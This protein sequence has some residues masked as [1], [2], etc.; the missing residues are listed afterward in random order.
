MPPTPSPSAKAS[1]RGRRPA[2]DDTAIDTYEMS[3]LIARTTGLKPTV[4][5]SPRGRARHDA[6]VKVC[7]TPEKTDIDDVAVVGIRPR[8]RL[9]AGNLGTADLAAV[10]RWTT[11]NEPAL[12]EFWDERSDAVELGGRLKKLE[13]G[14][15]D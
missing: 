9:V 14:M 15:A 1:L 8:P 6:R 13:G 12:M 2:E 3:N 11:L 5:V 7:L 4:W 10:T